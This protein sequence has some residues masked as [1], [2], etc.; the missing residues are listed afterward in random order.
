MIDVANA[1]KIQL[2][3]QSMWL[4]PQH[5]LFWEEKQILMVADLHLG[6]AGH[7]RKNGIPV[8]GHL[9]VSNLDRFDH[10]LESVDARHLIMLGDLF[11]SRKNREWDHFF[12]WRSRHA[13]LEITLVMGNHDILEHQA[14]H[15]SHIN[16]FNKLR[17]GPFLLV[18]DPETLQRHGTRPGYLLSGHIHPAVRL[19][20]KGRQSMKL[21]CFYFSANK[22]ILPAFGA[23]T[24]THVVK[25]APN[26]RVYAVVEDHILPFD[27][28]S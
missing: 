20:G 28:S 6:K 18:H 12:E 4:L 15:A 7:F 23:F 26:D 14:Y 27:R 2:Q 16:L 13:G 25:P 21:P 22:G 3:Q 8:P 17:I 11:H 9:N 1:R 19:R 10:L 5:A 24:G